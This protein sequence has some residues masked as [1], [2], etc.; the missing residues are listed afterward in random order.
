M[1]VAQISK[2]GLHYSAE[3]SLSYSTVVKA[4]EAIAKL[5]LKE[6]WMIIA[7][8]LDHAKSVLGPKL[9]LN[10]SLIPAKGFIEFYLLYTTVKEDATFHLAY[11]AQE[12]TASRL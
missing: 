2:V 3:D 12:S 8:D 10:E 5:D 7:E 9:L 1:I 6:T 4:K 11:N